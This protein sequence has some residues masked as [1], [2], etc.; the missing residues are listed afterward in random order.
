MRFAYRLYSVHWH[1]TNTSMLCPR[2][3]V[4]TWIATGS[5]D[6][7]WIRVGIRLMIMLM[8]RV[9]IMV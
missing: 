7:V 1:T 3:A 8:F 5:E 2:Q 4:R 6:K 9:R